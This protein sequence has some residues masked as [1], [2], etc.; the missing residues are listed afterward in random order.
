MF[1]IA[2]FIK[3]S[4]DATIM[5]S[6][7]KPANHYTN[8]FVWLP[9]KCA[10]SWDATYTCWDCNWET[11]VMFD[12]KVSIQVN[13]Y[14]VRDMSQSIK[15]ATCVKQATNSYLLVSRMKKMWCL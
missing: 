8:G 14:L 12:K 1:I 7:F 2:F 5:A 6:P 9:H 15:I 11:L 13:F 4:S 10:E 3:A